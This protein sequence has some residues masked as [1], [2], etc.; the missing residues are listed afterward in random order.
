METSLNGKE[1]HRHR[2]G[3]AEKGS[4]PRASE[5]LTLH[6]QAALETDLT[7]LLRVVP[8]EEAVVESAA[9]K[10]PAGQSA[11]SAEV[12]S[13]QALTSP[14]KLVTTK[15]RARSART[16]AS[17]VGATRASVAG[18]AEAVRCRRGALEAGARAGA[19]R[20]GRARQR[21]CKRGRGTQQQATTMRK[22]R[23][24]NDRSL[25]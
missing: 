19:A 2:V 4:R 13:G 6:R 12:R 24:R 11:T 16:G 8:H 21:A 20:V 17:R 25:R 15:A 10:E 3:M 1:K 14:N 18:S 23:K 22:A 7:G 5:A 9:Q